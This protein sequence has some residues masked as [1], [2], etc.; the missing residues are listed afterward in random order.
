MKKL[1]L[2]LF[3]ILVPLLV[4]AQ[5]PGITAAAFDKQ[6]PSQ[7]EL[8]KNLKGDGDVFWSTTFNFADPSNPRGWSWPEGWVSQ[9]NTEFGNFWIWS[10]DR[11]LGYYTKLPGIDSYTP[12]D[13]WL[14]LPSD[15]YNYRDNVQTLNNVDA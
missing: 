12:E 7:N 5:K 4:T 11:I 1:T 9:D 10:K 2:V 8:T 14:I 15:A 6:A 3:L 13:G